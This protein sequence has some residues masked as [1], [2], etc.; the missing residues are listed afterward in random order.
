MKVIPETH[1]AHY[2]W[3][4]TFYYYQWVDTSNG[5]LL[6]REVIIRPVVSASALIWVI[7]YIYYWNLQFLNNVIINKTMVLLSEAYVTVEDFD[8][9]D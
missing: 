7:K 9:S 3:Y 4:L 6:V 2:I 8:Y 1:R 5:V